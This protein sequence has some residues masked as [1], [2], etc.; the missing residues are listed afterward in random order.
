M[1]ENLEENK[2]EIMKTTLQLLLMFVSLF[3]SA[4]TDYVKGLKNPG[5]SVIIGDYLYFT[6]KDNVLG[7]G[8]ISKIDITKDNPTVI[9][10]LTGLNYPVDIDNVGNDLYYVELYD[11]LSKI[12]ISLNNPIPIFITDPTIN[13]TPNNR[14]VDVKVN[15]DYIYLSLHDDHKIV[16]VNIN[17]NF[18]TTPSVFLNG[19]SFPDGIDFKGN[20]MFYTHWETGT[21]ISKV[22]ITDPNLEPT[23]V[24]NHQVFATDIQIVGD[25]LYF[26]QDGDKDDIARVNISG[27]LPAHSSSFL[28]GIGSNVTHFLIK[29]SKIYISTHVNP[30]G[31][32][33]RHTSSTLS[34]KNID[35]N[36]N[37]I[38]SYPNPA[39]TSL[40]I[41]LTNNSNIQKIQ[42][43][44]IIGQ[45]LLEKSGNKASKIDLNVSKFNPGVYILK[46]FSDNISISKKIIIE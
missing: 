4:Q 29:G 8:K 20:D 31:K 19:V 35:T 39:K 2:K 30:G 44:N 10:V 37:E 18:P 15:G 24:E 45:K 1:L 43:Y 46:T 3:A 17:D 32:I 7:A 41:S 42:L 25:Y 27:N 14:I 13:P 34:V 40:T 11:G 16:R 9:D 28:S 5:E 26:N 38:T 12:D 23:I 36:S 6:Q 22:D 21:R 33:Q